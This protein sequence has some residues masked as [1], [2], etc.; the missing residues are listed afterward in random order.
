MKRIDE[1]EYKIKCKL[2]SDSHLFEMTYNSEVVN[3]ELMSSGEL[4]LFLLDDHKKQ[5]VNLTINPIQCY[6]SN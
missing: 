2:I 1:N 6:A 4:R 5:K 3:D